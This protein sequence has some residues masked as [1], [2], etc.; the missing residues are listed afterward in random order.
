[1]TFIEYL[2]GFGVFISM[3]RFME[4][5]F[6]IIGAGSAGCL[7]ANRLSANSNNKVSLIEAG[8]S[9]WSP[10]IHIPAGFM[11]TI[12][13]KRLNWLYETQPSFGTNGR[14]IPTPRGKVLGGSSSINGLIF[15]RGQ[16]T[17]FDNWAQRGNL[18][19]SYSDLLPHFKNVEKYIPLHNEYKSPKNDCRD[20]PEKWLLPT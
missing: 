15:N 1:M 3:L 7:L 20:E 6:I 11:K 18:V 12:A 13:N 4:F 2:I 16:K 5:D 14:S 17:D 19:W 10:F 8:P 9:D